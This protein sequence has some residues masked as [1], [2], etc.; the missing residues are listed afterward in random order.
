MRMTWGSVR[1]KCLGLI[2]VALVWAIALAAPAR[3]YVDGSDDACVDFTV[4]ILQLGDPDYSDGIIDISNEG[5][6]WVNK[7]QVG[8]LR[9]NQVSGLVL[10]SNV[11]TSDN[12]QDHDSHDK[13]AHVLVDPGFE[14]ILSNVNEPN[15]EHDEFVDLS[16]LLPATQIE[17]EWEVGTYPGEVNSSVP[18]RFHPR[19]AWPN[20]FDR[21][22]ADG[23]LI[24][25]CGH[26]KQRILG[27]VD[28]PAGGPPI[29]V[30]DAYYRSEIPPPAGDRVDAQ[31]GPRSPRNGHDACPRHRHGPLHP[32]ARRRGD[33]RSRMRHG[34][35]RGAGR[36]EL[37][38]PASESPRHAD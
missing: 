1:M 14:G 29:P 13:V 18:E 9:L 5:W 15:D 26:A 4:S 34:G 38:V 3:A 19:W 8:V 20:V 24:F 11:A 6:V 32:R 2:S 23:H 21:V 25:D 28:N 7:S 27:Y 33:R 10:K 37:P 30:K 22:W 35:A 31:P 12:A 16:E 17:L 36:R